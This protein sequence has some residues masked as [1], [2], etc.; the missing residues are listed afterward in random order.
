VQVESAW[1]KNPNYGIELIPLKTKAR[2]WYDDLLLA[3][4]LGCLRL[5][6][7]R[8]VDRLYFP[9]EDV[10]W[11]NFAVAEDAHTVCPWKGVADY[12]DLT[13]VEPPETNIVWTYR[14][15]FDQVGGIKG[16]VAFYQERTRIEVEERWP[17]DEPGHHRIRRFPGWGDEAELLRL[18]DVEQV[19]PQRF[20]GPAYGLTGRN[21][22]EG[23]Q[24]LGEA[25][26]A[27]SKTIPDKRVTSGYMTF[28][29]AASFNLPVD[30][31]VEVLRS[32]R[33][34]STV[35]IR[36]DQEGTFRSGGIMLMDTGAT[37]LIRHN[38]PMP[39]V[40]GPDAAEPLDMHV[41]GRDLRVVDGAYRA[42]PDLVGSPEI[43]T[44][45]RFRDDPGKQYLQA[46]L[47]AQSTTHWTIAAAMRPH[48]GFGEALAHITLSTGVMST[49]IAFLDEFDVTEWLLYQNPAV[50]AGRGLAQGEGRV[51]TQDGLLVATY[52]VQVMIRDFANTP[53]K[54]GL[55][56]TNAM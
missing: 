12:W 19:A 43:Y 53:E 48:R 21:V 33:T 44:W 15:P 18:M 13:A 37:D 16:Y 28:S 17:Q 32:G 51:F 5:E 45:C 36:I 23:G 31:S 46:A 14:D 34:F 40:P 39:D 20:V 30:V 38:V 42:E 22:V 24:L 3:E 47:L 26:V 9:E 7:E 29:R 4:S 35:G 54:M 11:E 10:H 55:N 1:L 27:A 41:A 49:A 25:I 8:H 50:Y 2:V 6:E 52:S 56:F